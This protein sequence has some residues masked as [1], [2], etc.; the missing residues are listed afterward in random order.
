MA[1]LGHRALV[2]LP[3]VWDSEPQP[4]PL[5]LHQTLCSLCPAGASTVETGD[6]G[7]YP[8]QVA[9]SHCASLLGQTCL[10]R[11]LL[12]LP[13]AKDTLNAW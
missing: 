11:L 5:S 12:W 2:T 9:W 6:V 1:Q 10:S 3:E 13:K 7:L 8:S 4:T